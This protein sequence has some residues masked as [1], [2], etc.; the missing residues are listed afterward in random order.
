M[1]GGNGS[2]KAEKFEGGFG[3]FWGGEGCQLG[4]YGV[5]AGVRGKAAELVQYFLAV[6]IQAR[7]KRH[8]RHALLAVVL[9]RVLRAGAQCRQCE[10][11]GLI[12][13]C[14]CAPRNYV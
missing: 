12:Q 6:R 11:R 3:D 2:K 1:G 13:N 9:G 7:T 8:V 4:N 14:T 5:L 10:H